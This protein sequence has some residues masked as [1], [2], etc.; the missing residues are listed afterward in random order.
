[1][2]N[3][4]LYHEGHSFHLSGDSK[5]DS[6]I[7]KYMI[8]TDEVII[9]PVQV[10]TLARSL[11]NSDPLPAKRAQLIA[12]GQATNL[13]AMSHNFNMD[14]TKKTV[15]WCDVEFSIP[16]QED[17]GDQG[18]YALHPLLRPPTFQLDM[19]DKTVPI[20]EAWNLEKFTHPKCL[21]EIGSWGPVT[22][23][24]GQ[25]TVDPI[26][27]TEHDG[28]ITITRNLTSYTAALNWINNYRRTTNSDQIGPFGPRTMRF[29]VTKCGPILHDDNIPY[30]E[31]S[32]T[33]FL[34]KSTDVRLNNVGYKRITGDGKYEDIN[35]SGETV[36]EPKFLDMH[37]QESW[38]TDP[39]TQEKK[40]K[41]VTIGYRFLNPVSYMPFFYPSNQLP[42]QYQ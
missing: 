38:E 20:E 19:I 15:W 3:C 35:G 36:S 13:Y 31:S 30:V 27:I 42:P 2:S 11:A 39:E 18:M 26:T 5:S 16:P 25:E 14:E 40:R 21:R 4:R 33:I 6:L 17:S 29:Q 28:I 8:T 1:M 32:T 12:G 24:A 7:Y 22:N 37:G 9:D 23:T 41:A 34:E 10:Y